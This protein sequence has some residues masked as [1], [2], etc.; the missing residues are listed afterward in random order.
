M[1]TLVVTDFTTTELWKRMLEHQDP[2]LRQ[3]AESL[4]GIVLG[5]REHTTG[6]K[7][8]L[9]AVKHGSVGFPVDVSSFILYLQHVGE[10]TGSH[11][12]VGMA[13]D[14]V[15][16]F[17]K[18]A[19]VEAVAQN[20]IVK[21]VRDGWKRKTAKPVKKKEPI[22]S[23]IL[24]EMVQSFGEPQSLAEVRLGSICLLTYAAFL[25]IGDIRA[26]RCCDIMFR[27][28]SMEVYIAQGK[29]DQLREGHSV[30][31][32]S[33][34]NETCPVK[35]LQNYVI[36]GGIDTSSKECF[37][38]A[39]TMTKEGGKL[40]KRGS[41]SYSR[42]RQ[43]VQKLTSLGYEAKNFGLHSFRAGGATTAANKGLPER[44]FKRHGRWRSE[45][46]KDG[47]MKDSL[48]KRLRVTKSLG[49]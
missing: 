47:Y 1:L 18:L 39:I 10:T 29:M 38:R 16:W 36:L 13:V 22:T 40:R 17:Q 14:A 35:M 42:M 15:A 44:L 7:L 33:T 49:L 45:R 23:E 48:E 19:G 43:L 27:E 31:I 34:G 21:A 12:A 9:W 3:L 2:E 30:P 6:G 28:D 5:S 41:L 46:A 26:L 20:S 32:A 25:R 4:P 37:F 8:G 11:A 24:L